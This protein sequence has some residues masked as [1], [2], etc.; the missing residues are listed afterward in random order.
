M[1]HV[2]DGR[3]SSDCVP[4]LP[5]HYN[6]ITEPYVAGL[7][8]CVECPMGMVQPF[9]NQSSCKL[10][11]ADGSV[12]C[13]DPSRVFVEQGYYIP[14]PLVVGT[15]DPNQFTF[16]ILAS[17]CS[18]RTR[19]NSG[20]LPIASYSNVSTIEE[21]AAQSILDAGNESILVDFSASG[22]RAA[23]AQGHTGPLC[24]TCAQNYYSTMIGCQAC[25]TLQEFTTVAWT[26]VI[27]IMIVLVWLI[28]FLAGGA[29]AILPP[30]I[31]KRF[32]RAASRYPGIAALL[33]KPVGSYLRV[34]IAV[35]KITISFGHCVITFL[36]F[37]QAEWPPSLYALFEGFAA[38]S[39][40]NFSP[41][42][43][44]ILECYNNDAY[45]YYPM[46]RITL[47]LPIAILS[48][49]GLLL[50]VARITANLTG[51]AALHPP[52]TE[53]GVRST[54]IES[55]TNR[56]THDKRQKLLRFL[57]AERAKQT[58]DAITKRCF[59]RV[60]Q[61]ILRLPCISWP[62]H[63][64]SV[65]LNSVELWTSG[66]LIMMLLYPSVCVASLSIFDTAELCVHVYD[67]PDSAGEM[68][69][70]RIECTSYMNADT[71][72]LYR[73]D[74]W[75]YHFYLCLLGA[76]FYI[77]GIPMFFWIV[78]RAYASPRLPTPVRDRVWL[79][80]AT[81]NP[82]FGSFE[83]FECLRRLLL[84]G[85]IMLVVPGS[86]IQLWFGMVCSV[87]CLAV[88][89]ENPYRDYAS[90]FVQMLF[91]VNLTLLYLAS[92]LFLSSFALTLT[93][94]APP[95]DD[96]AE[97]W[98]RVLFLVQSFSLISV[99]CVFIS[100]LRD[101]GREKHGLKLRYATDN[102]PVVLEPPLA[103]RTGFHVFLS[104]VCVCSGLNPN[105]WLM[106]WC[107]TLLP[108]NPLVWGSSRA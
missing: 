36:R 9:A 48:L 77:V 17:R 73:G 74:E 75:Y 29:E 31:V 7:R 65:A 18:Q 42:D 13:A 90:Y 57:A 84:T 81:Y 63:A 19:C 54:S 15:R 35:M 102:H 38:L 23:C 93:F 72:L 6:E 85:V 64:C 16:S 37:Y 4:C 21:A 104:H 68:S 98:G 70:E 103:G 89:R 53:Q 27:V 71:R 30:R 58:C 67:V 12:N 20:W 86:V 8:R 25:P 44:R 43:A 97:N 83:V 55:P 105:F 80:T 5:G 3:G 40:F 88:Y 10:C 11:A 46:L 61:A 24:G 82:S 28:M 39:I 92:S 91:M 34:V 107:R 1:E 47:A 94:S 50:V 33:A 78:T 52:L 79:L 26:Y 32:G 60:W 45:S 62:R 108:A 59:G 101:S 56:N 95:G 41:L 69:Q 99:L 87:G 14:T 2:P 96:V 100:A 22:R 49:L 76:G 51:A 66:I 106:P